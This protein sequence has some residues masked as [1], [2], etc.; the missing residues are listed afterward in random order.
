VHVSTPN[1]SH[2]IG[3]NVTFNNLQAKELPTMKITYMVNGKRV[4]GNGRKVTDVMVGA[5]VIMGHT[6]GGRPFIFGH[7]HFDR[8]AV[9]DAPSLSVAA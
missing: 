7:Q 4:F 2:H 1:T 9:K 8:V 5:R 3:D 6:A